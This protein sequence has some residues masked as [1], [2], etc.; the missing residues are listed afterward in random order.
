MGA[1]WRA[2]MRSSFG[3]LLLACSAVTTSA[4]R[5]DLASS[6]T[7]MTIYEHCSEEPVE[8][9]TVNEWPLGKFRRLAHLSGDEK[10]LRHSEG[11]CWLL[12]TY[13]REGIRKRTQ[14][15]RVKLVEGAFKSLSLSADEL[16]RDDGACDTP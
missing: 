6:E 11:T 5:I 14:P 13:C 8:A 1:T 3:V 15:T 4:A 10:T 2:S 12:G 16:D 7:E 9:G